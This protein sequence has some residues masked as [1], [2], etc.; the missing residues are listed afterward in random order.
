M[1]ETPAEP[2]PEPLKVAPPEFD[3]IE[4]SDKTAQTFE[5]R[6]SADD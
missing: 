5:R 6:D 4:K 3:Y 2:Q 1:S